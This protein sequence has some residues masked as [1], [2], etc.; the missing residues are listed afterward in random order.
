MVQPMAVA[1]AQPE[2]TTIDLPPIA[3]GETYKV[4]L[5][6]PPA[7]VT[8]DDFEPMA[9]Q[10]DGEQPEELLWNRPSAEVPMAVLA[11]NARIVEEPLLEP[12]LIESSQRV[13]MA[14]ALAAYTEGSDAAETTLSIDPPSGKLY[15]VRSGDSIVGLLKSEWN[16]SGADSINAFLAVNPKVRARKNNIIRIGE[17]VVIPSRESAMAHMML[18]LSDAGHQEAE[19]K[20]SQPRS[21]KRRLYKVRPHDTLAKIARKELRDSDRWV[22]IYKLNRM[23]NADVIIPG[24]EIMLPEQNGLE[25]QVGA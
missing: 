25:A 11:S 15:V 4:G 8:A 5:T 1:M 6:S 12:L 9:A 21:K 23:K 3:A 24:T 10:D 2:E 19:S 17:T 16:H 13:D 20:S 22:E 18:T 7:F 14:A